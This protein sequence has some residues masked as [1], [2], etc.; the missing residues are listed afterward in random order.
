MRL[1]SAVSALLIAV[2]VLGSTALRAADAADAAS[3][4][5]REALRS[6]TQQLQAAQAERDTLQAA[7][8]GLNEEKKALA[9]QADALRKQSAADKIA[10]DKI[11]ADLRAKSA[12]QDAE[13]A[14]LKAE[15]EKTKADRDQAATLAKTTEAE[16]AKLAAANL[17]LQQ[18]VVDREAKNRE[19]FKTGK[20]ILLRYEKFSLGEALAAKEPFVG[21]T[22]VKL[23]NLVQGYDDKLIEQ[24]AMP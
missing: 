16:R 5:L 11:A 23:E 4:R 2:S 22:R 10:T 14:R 7:Q 6:T 19:L 15:L 8:A 20:E 18:L 21:T 9:A 3:A 12:E 1:S 24:R 13:L 17:Q